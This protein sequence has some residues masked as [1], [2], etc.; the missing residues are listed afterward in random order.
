MSKFVSALKSTRL[1]M[2]LMIT[3]LLQLMLVSTALA[4]VQYSD[5]RWSTPTI[6]EH[7]GDEWTQMS[8]GGY[9]NTSTNYKSYAAH[10]WSYAHLYTGDE[11]A[12]WHYPTF[13]NNYYGEWQAYITSSGT[14]TRA[15]YD[16]GG[17]IRVLNQYA[18]HGWTN[19][20]SN[21]YMFNIGWLSDSH[22]GY[23]WSPT[24]QADFDGTRV[25][26]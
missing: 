13:N 17:N 20:V 3:I 1:F 15:L 25:Y 2:F 18:V 11:S 26:Y 6:F 23:T 12:W 16:S 7:F 9:Y 22:D 19:L 8:S 14:H 5:W 24:Q 10:G 21:G 4:T